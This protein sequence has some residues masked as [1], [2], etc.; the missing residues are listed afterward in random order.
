MTRVDFRL[1][2]GQVMARWVKHYGIETIVVVDNKTSKS[3]ILK[4]ILLNMAPAGIK[5]EVETVES[6]VARWNEN[7]F[8]KNNLLLLFK[9]PEEAKRAWLDGIKFNRLQVG[10]IEG[11][12]NKKNICR[13]I[14]M[15]KDDV[16]HLKTMYDGGVTIFCQ[17]I[18]E[19]A[20]YPFSNALAKF[21]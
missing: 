8:P 19:D 21:Y 13:N 5:V 15:S 12:G 7:K 3:P 18:P 2:H 1:I 6:A 20:E 17:P 11:A 16:D 14:T 9:T 4:K 10:G